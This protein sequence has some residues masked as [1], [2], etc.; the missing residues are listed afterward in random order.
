VTQDTSVVSRKYVYK[1][2]G[3]AVSIGVGVAASVPSSQ[4]WE[5]GE[6]DGTAA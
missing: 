5:G 2:V 3:L 6:G 4:F 1:L